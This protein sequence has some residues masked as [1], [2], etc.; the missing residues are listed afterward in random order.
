MLD[1]REGQTKRIASGPS[2]LVRGMFVKMQLELSPAMPLVVVP[3][4]AL[5]PGNRV[6]RFVPDQSVLARDESIE[7]AELDGSDPEDAQAE[8]DSQESSETPD[9]ATDNSGD[10]I[11]LPDGQVE[12][13]LDPSRWVAGRL[14]VLDGV[15]PVD[16]LSKDGSFDGE[17]AAKKGRAERTLDGDYW[18]C[19]VPPGSLDG[20]SYVVV[21]PL[22]TVQSGSVPIRV[23]ATQV[24]QAA[25]EGATAMT[26]TAP[27]QA[28]AS[29]E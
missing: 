7:D 2:A 11:D 27:D 12:S 8:D 13:E 28:D 19:E 1:R 18:I 16:S 22:G 20:E 23:P 21:S 6:W 4:E 14:V 26:M 24:D 10:E 15:R 25:F 5:R 17:T 9:M 29:T 3:A